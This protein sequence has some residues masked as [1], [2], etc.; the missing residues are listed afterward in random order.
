MTTAKRP[1]VAA[2]PAPAPEPLTEPAD[3]AEEPAPPLVP[4]KA[5]DYPVPRPLCELCG[6]PK[7]V[8]VDDYLR[9]Y[10]KAGPK[11]VTLSSG[12][13]FVV[14]KPAVHWLAITGRLHPAIAAL[15]ADKAGLLD[16][17]LC[18]LEPDEW[19]LLV[20]YS[21]SLA[22][23]EPQVSFNEGVEG[24]L[25]VQRIAEDDARELLAAAEIEV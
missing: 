14:D 10:S 17:G 16:G 6:Q 23:I 3:E 13:T 9:H 7:P 8:S 5:E 18:P 20:N 1:R 12:A 25:W 22:I 11:A 21:L 4:T 19:R 2:K 15:A 24:R